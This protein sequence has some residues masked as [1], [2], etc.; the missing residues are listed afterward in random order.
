MP[1]CC[2]FFFLVF[3]GRDS[4]SCCG[5]RRERKGQSRNSTL[6]S[7]LCPTFRLLSALS[8]SLSLSLSLCFFFSSCLASFSFSFASLLLL[9]RPLLLLDNK[10]ATDTKKMRNGKGERHT[11][12]L[13]FLL[14]VCYC[15]RIFCCINVAKN[16]H[17]TYNVRA[18]GETYKKDSTAQHI[19][20]TH[21]HIY[22]KG[23]RP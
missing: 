7:S 8:F 19:T 20:V 23:K 16:Y 22:H 17:V 12:L 13:L 11:L 6:R 1:N 15:C 4:Y 18:K 3:L 9:S 21:I 5:R 14:F 2:D 10:R